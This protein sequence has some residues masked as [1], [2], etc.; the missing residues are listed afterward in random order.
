MTADLIKRAQ[1]GMIPPRSGPAFPMIM[2]IRNVDK[3]SRLRAQRRWA[4]V[5]QSGY[6]IINEQGRASSSFI[7]RSGTS[8]RT[9]Y[10]DVYMAHK[11]KT[12]RKTTLFLTEG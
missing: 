1:D 3:E 12:Y 7:V 8:G 11:G 5:P 2:P 6:E 4:I 10:V 9:V